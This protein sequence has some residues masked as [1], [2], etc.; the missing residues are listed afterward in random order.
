MVGALIKILV[1][2]KAQTLDCEMNLDCK[3]NK[4]EDIY[5]VIISTK[6]TIVIGIQKQKINNK[7]C[8]CN[9]DDVT[10]KPAKRKSA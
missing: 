1:I 8:K 7:T 5:T 10:N 6:N 2:F 3:P 4:F 9:T